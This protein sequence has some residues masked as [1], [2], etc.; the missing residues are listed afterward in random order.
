MEGMLKEVQKSEPL[1][2]KHV[3]PLSQTSCGELEYAGIPVDY[4]NY[5]GLDMGKITEK[6]REKLGVIASLLKP[7]GET[8]G[9]RLTALRS[10]ERKLGRDPLNGR[11]DSVYNHMRLT[12]RIKDLE[13][14]RMALETSNG[15]W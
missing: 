9:D 10:L 13:K 2:I 5:F 12:S 14:Q 1:E 11:L 6:Q 7:D 4:Y 3:T 15:N 8:L